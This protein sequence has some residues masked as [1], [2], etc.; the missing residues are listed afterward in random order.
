[1]VSN[2][3][4]KLNF[5]I[6]AELLGTQIGNATV[7]DLIFMHKSYIKRMNICPFYKEALMTTCIFDL[8][9]GIK[10]AKLWDEE[11]LFCNPLITGKNGTFIKETAY[12]RKKGIYRLGH[13]LE[14]VRKQDRGDPYDEKLANFAK[15]IQT[16]MD[17]NTKD[18]VILNNDKAVKMSHITQ[19]QLYEDAIVRTTTTHNYQVKWIDK[20]QTVVLWEEVWK[21]VHNFLLTS[22]LKP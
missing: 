1:M 6:F 4:L 15:D 18:L 8:R 21:V 16:N 14:E 10:D 12:F 22:K 20:L 7:R 2:P 17:V 19:K 11:Y 3:A 9:K 5:A 13:L